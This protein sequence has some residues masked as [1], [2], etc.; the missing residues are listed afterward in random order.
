MTVNTQGRAFWYGPKGEQR[1]FE[2]GEEVPSG[3]RDHPF[4]AKAAVESNDDDERNAPEVIAS[5][6]DETDLDAL[7]AAEKDREKPR[8]G[9]LDAI[10][11][12]RKARAE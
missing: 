6:N 7:E 3:W 1:I 4:D 10:E 5:I 2:P 9:V 11:K 8:K 12:A